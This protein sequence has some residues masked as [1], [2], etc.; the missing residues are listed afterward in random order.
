MADLNIVYKIAADISGLQSGVDRAAASAEKLG[1]IA[2]K[3]TGVFAGV[4][5][6][7]AAISF[8]KALLDDADALAKLSDQTGISVEGLQKL[9]IVGDD[10]GNTIDD[11]TAAIT[12]LQDK[13]GSGDRSAAKALEKLGLA[14][15]DL[16]NLNPENQFLLIADRLGD[17][18]DQEELVAIGTDLFGK[19]FANI[20]P[21]IKRGFDDVRD[22]SVGMS[23]ET[24]KS[25]DEFGDG[26]S[27]LWRNMKGAAGTGFAEALETA[28]DWLHLTTHAV[29]EAQ[30]EFQSFN[31]T[32]K[33]TTDAV[34][35]PKKGLPQIAPLIVPTSEDADVQRAIKDIDS[36]LDKLGKTTR[37]Y[38]T[39][40]DRAAEAN[41]RFRESV[42]N[43]TTDAIGAVQGF[44]MYGQL[45]PDLST[46]TA[47]LT[48]LTIALDSAIDHTTDD[49]E[50]L[51][52]EGRFL[53][54][55]VQEINAGLMTLP[56]GAES[57]GAA[58]W[59]VAGEAEEAT[60]IFDGFKGAISDVWEGLTSGKGFAGLFQN[61]GLGIIHEFGALITAGI[62]N[63]ISTGIGLLGKGIKKLFEIG[64]PS[65]E[66]VAGRGLVENFEDELAGTLTAQQKAE[67]GGDAWKATIIAVRDAYVKAGKSASDAEADVA[68]LWEAS[69]QGPEAVAAA[70]E[71]IRQNMEKA[72]KAQDDVN[73]SVREQKDAH[74]DALEAAK[75]AISD[76]QQKRQS[77]A[78][79]IAGEAPEEVMGVIEA[80]TRGQIAV[81]DQE[82]SRQQTE[83]ERM[84][85]AI[86]KAIE[87]AINNIHTDPIDIEFN[88]K[89][90]TDPI[91]GFGGEAPEIVPM[92]LGGMGTVTRPTLFMAGE[93]GPEHFAFSGGGRRFGGGDTG[94]GVSV[95]AVNV[96]MTVTENVDRNRLA[97]DFKEVLRSDATVYEAV[98]VVARRE[99]VAS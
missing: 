62:S 83:L 11:F 99:V 5:T 90:P 70:I 81:L 48:D 65:K 71:K 28:N 91:L 67:A 68:A 57:A 3:L 25:L 38:S 82:I 79:S 88:V 26:L 4:F 36:A 2:T 6:V 41:Q 72:E 55:A 66:E 89:H 61:L 98:R 8:G 14:F 12:K 20:L 56:A 1:G 17:I 19:S 50:A 44:G 77:L 30:R 60:S 31:D 22:A 49:I 78:D 86:A 42:K 96:Q 69:K 24:V 34:K 27:R 59:E 33:E 35:A 87:D 64:G 39:D 93:F 13:L 40:A 84:A 52:R 15:E 53:S 85:E 16:E 63:L 18:K 76:L 80:Q 58:I 10:A 75:K 47:D 37:S 97:E 9:Q 74:N 32:L 45:L 51:Q 23:K 7:Q 21:S 29:G 54:V 43:L 94:D 73:D 92:A 95:G 46:K